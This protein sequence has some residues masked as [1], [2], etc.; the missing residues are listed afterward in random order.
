MAI[1]AARHFAQQGNR[2]LFVTHT[3]SFA[4]EALFGTPLSKRPQT[5]APQLQAVALQS[6]QLLDQVWDEVKSWLTGYLPSSVTI[7]VYPGEVMI[8]PGFDSILTFNALRQYFDSQDYDV[9]LYDGQCGLETLRMLGLPDAASWYF[10][11]FRRVYESLDISKVAESIGGPIA[12]AFVSA[13]FDS[14]KMED[15]MDL[16]RSWISKGVSVVRDAKRLTTYLV[17]DQE[18][19][20]IAEAQWLWGSAQQVDLRISGVLAYQSAGSPDLTALRSTF[21]P[22]PITVIPA[23]QQQNWTPLLDA[24]PD[25]NQADPTIPQ[26]VTIDVAQRL[27][28]VFLPGFQKHEVKL[29]QHGLELTIEAGDQRRNILLPPELQNQSV[30]GGKFE[31]PYLIVSF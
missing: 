28:R 1:A 7:E 8:L 16:V 18:P 2:T 3:P 20:A 30:T 4:A 12:S 15:G 23:L 31:A 27:V 14:R 17:V 22:L 29:T 21:E 13:N 10:R 9:V 19:G 11:R 6:T 5:L 26:P 25:F 24:L